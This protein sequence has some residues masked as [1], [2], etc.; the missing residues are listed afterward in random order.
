MAFKN[1]KFSNKIK[2]RC[3]HLFSIGLSKKFGI[4]QKFDA[5]VFGRISCG[6]FFQKIQLNSII[7]QS[8]FRSH[9][10]KT[11]SIPRKK[12]KLLLFFSLSFLFSFSFGSNDYTKGRVFNYW[13]T[14]GGSNSFV[15]INNLQT[16]AVL[17][18]GPLLPSIGSNI[19][20]TTFDSQNLMWF[21]ILKI[22]N[23]FDYAIIGQRYN[24]ANDTLT[25]AYNCTVTPQVN[26]KI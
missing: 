3:R 12:M 15:S 14:S 16:G 10:L 17:Y 24:Q 26:K 25:F 18:S 6:H 9:F 21:S 8:K 23:I 13:L 4:L 7:Q 19:Y 20:S 1:I 11:N 2:N 22:W 5:T